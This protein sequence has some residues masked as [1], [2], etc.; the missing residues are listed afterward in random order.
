[1]KPMHVYNLLKHRLHFQIRRIIGTLV[2]VA[3]GELTKRDVYEMLTIPS[4]SWKVQTAP[5]AGLYLLNV[6]YKENS[7][8]F[9]E[10]DVKV[11]APELKEIPCNT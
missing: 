1:M 10:D 7:K 6:R 4:R 5:A 2:G 3:T 9:V 11:T 8:S